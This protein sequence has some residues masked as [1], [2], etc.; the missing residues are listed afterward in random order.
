MV[1]LLEYSSAGGG[2]ASCFKIFSE[3]F[4]IHFEHQLDSR[5]PAWGW[6]LATRQEE[7]LSYGIGSPLALGSLEISLGDMDLS[8]YAS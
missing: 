7:H 8:A 5:R 6:P 1:V 3:A 2:I 4:H